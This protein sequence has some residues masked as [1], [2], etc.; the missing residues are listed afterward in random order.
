[1]RRRGA[2]EEEEGMKTKVIVRLVAEYDIEMEI[3]HREGEEPTNLTDGERYA[4]ELKGPVAP[5]WRFEKAWKA[6]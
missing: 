6:Q 1:V 2:S 5:K 3:E 4:A